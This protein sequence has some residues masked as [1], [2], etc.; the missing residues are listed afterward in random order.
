MAIYV[1]QVA[2]ALDASGIESDRVL[3]AVGL[4]RPAT[5][6]PFSRVPVSAL[7]RL[8][9]AAV[10]ATGD[11][12]FG[13]KVAGFIEITH[14]HALGHGLAVSATLMEFCERLRRYMRLASH[15]CE[16]ELVESAT[17]VRLILVLREEVEPV[18][19]DA[20]VAFLVHAMRRLYKQEFNPMRI[21][22]HHAMPKGG[23]ARYED[24]FKAPVEF[25][26]VNPALSFHKQD[27]V[28]V[29]PGRSAELAEVHD[30]LAM[31]DLARLESDDVVAVVRQK[32]ADKLPNGE[33]TRE[34]VAAAMCMSAT[35]LRSRLARQGTTF[36]EL[37]DM[38]RRELALSYVRQLGRPL[39]G[40]TFLLGFS[41][42]SHFS[43][44][45]K[46]WAGMSPRAFR[47]QLPS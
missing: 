27:L 25:G 35:T 23:S 15:A 36:N 29:L 8:C 21:A 7:N 34:N 39:Y 32:I 46:R 22:F 9:A 10:A 6:D 12:Y 17:E 43:R 31:R 4:S 38:T 28:Q 42:V 13:L 41:D 47:K 44:A 11:E 19:E 30:K 33:C 16:V 1:H 45:F 18:R 40:I 26:H 20:F 24:I 3:K 5:S 14:L 2:K 37:L